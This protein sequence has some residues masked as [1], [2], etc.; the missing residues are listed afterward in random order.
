MIC[1]SNASEFFGGGLFTILDLNT[2]KGSTKG[3]NSIDFAV[4]HRFRLNAK[5]KIRIQKN[6]SGAKIEFANCKALNNRAF[7]T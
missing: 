3:F 2:F 5:A 4:C 1:N 7:R 6:L